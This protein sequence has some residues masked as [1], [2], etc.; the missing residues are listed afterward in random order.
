MVIN[1]PDPN[2][3]SPQVTFFTAP[4]GSEDS[5]FQLQMNYAADQQF[6]G[7]GFHVA[8]VNNSV[9]LDEERS[10]THVALTTAHDHVRWTSVMAWIDNKLYFAVKDGHCGDWGDF[11][12]P[13]YLVEMPTSLSDLSGYRAQQSLDAVDIGF[14][15]NRV[16]SVTLREV[17][18]YYSDGTRETV[19]VNQQP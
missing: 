16:N 14:G 4:S 9:M 3:H 2:S 19:P 11:G 1:E 15:G 17:V 7:G 5:Y 6:S 8:A 13:D 12:G 10:H 18:R